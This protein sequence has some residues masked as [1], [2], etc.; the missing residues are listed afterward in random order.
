MR[1]AALLA[2]STIYSTYTDL[3]DPARSERA[4]TQALEISR[5]IG[6]RSTQARLHWNLMVTYLFSNR[7]DQAM[8]HGERALPLARESG[9][10]DQL[11]FI[12]NDLGRV[13]AC[14]GKFEQSYEVTREARKIW[15]DL[16]N[17]TML[18]DSLG[19]EAST[20]AQIGDHQEALELLKEG[21][22]LS[23]KTEN[24]WG[25]SYLRMVLSLVHFDQGRIR[26]G[27]QTSEQCV[28]TGDQAGLMAS[29]IAHRAELGWYFGHYGAFEKG[30]EAAEKALQLADEEQSN[31]RTF[32]LAIII[33]LHLMKGDLESAQHMAG[34]APLRPI[35][36]PYAHYT[37]TVRLANVE[38]SL[39]QGNYAHALS[40]ADALLEEVTPLIRLNIPLVLQ[41]RASALIGLNRIDEAHQILTQA[42]SLAEEMDSRHHLW[43]IYIDLAE[44]NVCLEHNDEAETF[45]QKA[46]E[47]IE[48]IA[49]DLQEID[50]KDSF[51]EQPRVQAFMR[52]L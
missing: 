25:Q 45:R 34:P 41:R 42:C 26:Q 4:I 3:H 7:P 22:Q 23:E 32:P 46:R 38:L 52:Q 49:D 35:S 47:I 50:L 16:K 28:T 2:K 8:E 33:L 10:R 17:E 30:F 40:L 19:S 31:F 14:Q 48:V 5:E 24:L 21:L 15:R 29:S 51:L 11:A 43:S 44:V 36:I 1:L 12:L 20:R 18:A 6:D 37:I 9:D 13:Y 27:I 39:A